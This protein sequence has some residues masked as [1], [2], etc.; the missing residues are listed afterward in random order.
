MA[1]SEVFFFFFKKSSQLKRL[2]H[3]IWPQYS[4][5]RALEQ[6]HTTFDFNGMYGS[7]I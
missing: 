4:L 2:D 3:V 5:F 7:Q 1:D 6:I